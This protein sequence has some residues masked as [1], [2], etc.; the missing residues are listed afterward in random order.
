MNIL[1]SNPLLGEHAFSYIK[2]MGKKFYSFSKHVVRNS[3]D[4][5]G[6][7]VKS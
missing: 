1:A 3:H 7:Y 2:D 4:L 6:L 5:M